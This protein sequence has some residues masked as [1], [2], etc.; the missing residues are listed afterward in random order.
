VTPKLAYAAV[1]VLA[2]CATLHAQVPRI[3]AGALLS[4]GTQSEL[5]GADYHVGGGARFAVNATRYLAGELEYTRQPSSFPAYFGNEGH[6]FIAAK[7]TY[8][9]EER[10]WLRFAGMNIFGVIGP[11]L[12][13]RTVFVADPNPPPF[14]IRCTV[15]R[16]QTTSMFEYGGGVE[17]IP[18]RRVAVRFDATRGSFTEQSEFSSYTVSQSRTYF[19]LAVVLRV[20]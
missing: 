7:G 10:R 20:P 1:L 6:T 5:G 19:K 12:V 4:S 3:E 2:C 13:N 8:R 14:C 18:A 17:I 11:A 15:Q 16:R 9:V